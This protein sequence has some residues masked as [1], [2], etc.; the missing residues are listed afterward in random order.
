MESRVARDTDHLVLV[1]GAAG[2][3]GR[4]LVVALL[5]ER[6][7]VRVLVR[8]ADAAASLAALG[9]ESMVGDLLEPAAIQRAAAGVT[10]VFH[11]AGRLF[12][13]AVP[14]QEYKRLHVDA[15]VALLEACAANQ[16]ESFVL[17]STTG[18]HGPTGPA[19]ARED[20]AGHPQNA[21]ETTKADAERAAT[22]VAS[23]A[24]LPLIIARPGLVYGPGDRHLLGWFRSIR[25]GYYRVIGSGEN[26]LHPIYIDDTVRALRL[27]AAARQPAGRAYHLV[28]SR[29]VTM[30]ELS[31]AI[32]TAVGRAVPRTHLPSWLAYTAGAALEALPVPRRL[33]PLTRSRVRFMLQNRE[34]DGT[35]A[36][37]ELGFVPSV[38]LADGLSRAVAWYED[39]GLL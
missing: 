10:S 15:T 13:P 11:L 26:K 23:R 3:I 37:E 35:R 21:Y 27:C 25:A 4:A 5:A 18:V 20:D 7:R 17:C 2:F 28:G 31:D 36:R 29:A 12:A 34:Y 39:Q 24:A 19:P 1:T 38:N 14:A 9:A 8:R 6:R 33:L 30:R 16:L 32:G 22:V